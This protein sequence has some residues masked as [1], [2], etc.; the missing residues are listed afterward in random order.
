LTYGRGKFNIKD[1]LKLRISPPGCRS[2]TILV[3]G[4]EILLVKCHMDAKMAITNDV[5]GP[6]LTYTE[7]EKSKFK[8]Y[9]R[10]APE[11]RPRGRPKG[12]KKKRKGGNISVKNRTIAKTKKQKHMDENTEHR[13]LTEKTVIKERPSKSPQKC[14]KTTRINW[15][16]AENKG[17]MDRVVTSWL[18]KKDLCLDRNESLRTLRKRRRVAS[19]TLNALGYAGGVCVNLNDSEKVQE[20]KEELQFADLL[21]QV[22]RKGKICLKPPKGPV[23]KRERRR[24]RVSK[25]GLW[26]NRKRWSP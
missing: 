25:S 21:N 6:L 11:K 23:R 8:E 22:R 19:R 14:V 17:Y 26:P 2:G 5:V 1:H 24:E 15:D 9:F 3:V 12:S 4:T 18:E 10:Q 13:Q 16:A 20:M 7:N